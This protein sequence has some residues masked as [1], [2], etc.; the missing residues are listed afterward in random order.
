LFEQAGF[1]LFTAILDAQWF[2]VPQKRLRLIVVGLNTELYPDAR[3]KFAEA[4]SLTSPSTVRSAIADLPEPAYFSRG[5]RPSD[6]PYHPNHWTMVPRSPKFSQSSQDRVWPR[7]RS[8]RMLGWDVPSWTVAYGN[9]EV[10]I[11][12]DGHRRL[13]VYEAMLLQGFPT[14]YVLEGTLSDQFRLV[15]D[16]VP[17]P[18]ASTVA[19][20][21]TEVIQPRSA[22]LTV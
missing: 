4:P 13:S 20:A 9:R 1:R 18:L 22:M 2:G 16:A 6:I 15:S 17:P 21:L 11:H 12:P 8:F 7:G 5:L 14:T 3:F 19:R 10:H